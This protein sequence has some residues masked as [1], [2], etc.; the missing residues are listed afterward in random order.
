MTC[1][2]DSDLFVLTLAE[3]RSLLLHLG[4]SGGG[5]WSAT[6]AG[7]FG[8][9]AVAMAKGPGR[10]LLVA[11]ED[12]RVYLAGLKQIDGRWELAGTRMVFH[13]LARETLGLGPAPLNGLAPGPDGT[14]YLAF[15]PRVL[16][17][18]VDAHGIPNRL[19]WV[20][21]SP[22]SLGA[23]PP[24]GNRRRVALEGPV[25]LTVD[26]AGRVY[27][28]DRDTGSITIHAAPGRE[29]TVNTPR[30]SIPDFHPW[31]LAS[32]GDQLVVAGHTTGPC[33]PLVLAALE[34]IQDGDQIRLAEGSSLDVRMAPGAAFCLTPS[35]H[36]L[37]ADP[38]RC[39]AALWPNGR[40]D[41][42]ERNQPGV[43]RA[44]TV[45]RLQIQVSIPALDSARSA[46]QSPAAGTQSQFVLQNCPEDTETELSPVGKEDQARLAELWAAYSLKD[47]FLRFMDHWF[48]QQHDLAAGDAFS[49][50][51]L[52]AEISAGHAVAL[53]AQAPP[54]IL[55]YALSEKALRRSVGW[56]LQNVRLANSAPSL[57]QDLR[58]S[59]FQL[60]LLENGDRSFYALGV[61]DL[62]QFAEL[63]DQPYG[64]C[65]VTGELNATVGITGIR[66]GDLT[67]GLTLLFSH[68]R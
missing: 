55:Q 30:W 54:G 3:P 36:L 8:F 17:C 62:E 40:L 67:R 11:D 44:P 21:G 34:V 60:A 6:P 19:A 13:D 28:L 68:D 61:E 35:G 14:V 45:E 33:S 7:K 20:G 16:R 38:L 65:L 47:S 26:A 46:A 53:P 51:V 42:Q 23:G 52:L 2:G 5:S 25:S 63:I 15:G 43:Q 64:D 32:W 10:S 39:Q 24:A 4:P 56:L 50:R 58:S 29:G 66:N 31:E 59:R 49:L 57:G 37:C 18:Q 22:P 1:L 12:G 27:L 9:R 41:L 48:Q